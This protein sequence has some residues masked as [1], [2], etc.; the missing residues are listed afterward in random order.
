[1][2]F[3]NQVYTPY[4]KNFTISSS[5]PAKL[6]LLCWKKGRWIA[7]T[8][9]VLQLTENKPHGITTSHFMRLVMTLGHTLT[10]NTTLFPYSI[11]SSFCQREFCRFLLSFQIPSQVLEGVLFVFWLES[12]ELLQKYG[13]SYP[14]VY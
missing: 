12:L 4:P 13:R 11:N 9:R 14:R 3:G 7:V 6:E 10:Y 8:L 2:F 5:I 1:M